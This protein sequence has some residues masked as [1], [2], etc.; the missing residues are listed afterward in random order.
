ML[1]FAPC[2]NK[3]VLRFAWII[4]VVA[5]SAW[6][7]PKLQP[8]FASEVSTPDETHTLLLKAACGDGV[9]TVTAKGQ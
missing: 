6:G 4:L 1:P 5:L 8:T 7:A 9:R 2:C 3:R